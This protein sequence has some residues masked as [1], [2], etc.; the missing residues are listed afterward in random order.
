LIVRIASV[1]LA[2]L[3]LLQAGI[4]SYADRTSLGGSLYLVNRT[5]RL[6]E[7][8]VPD[9]LVTV[10]V[11]KLNAGIKLRREAALHLEEMFNA[12]KEMKMTLVAVSG[13]RSFDQQ[14]A[15]YARKQKTSGS[16]EVAM[17]LVAPAGASEHQ[18]GLAV[19]IGRTSSSNLNGA[20]GKSREGQWVRENAHLF[21]FIIRYKAEWTGITGYADEP[22]HIRYVGKEHAQA[23]NALNVPLETYIESL[24][25]QS[26]G[27]YYAFE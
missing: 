9:D 10:N 27:E 26:F 22:W 13:Y 4:A 6:T 18:L 7:A 17:L 3:N 11:R 1:L 20:F 2:C 24:A 19:D 5:Y 21:G 14:K 23:I 16:K 25:L 15:I 12:A 8:Y